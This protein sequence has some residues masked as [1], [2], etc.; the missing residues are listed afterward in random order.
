MSETLTRI[1]IMVCTAQRPRMLRDCVESLLAQQLADDWQVEVCVV[2]NDATPNSRGVV[3][4]MPTSS[5]VKVRYYQEPRRGIPFARNKTLEVGLANG[6][7][8]IVLIDDDER[9]DPTWLACLMRTAI[10]HGADV[11]SGPVRRSYEAPPP[12][13]WKLLKPIVGPAGM[14]LDEAPTNNTLLSAKLIRPDGGALRFAEALT[15]G[16]EDIDFFSR[17]YKLGFRIVWSPDAFVEETI[18]ASRVQPERLI[19]RVHSTAAAQVLAAKI[20]HGDVPTVAKFA[21]KG[22]RRLVSGAF[23]CAL[24]WPGKGLGWEKPTNSYYR[25]RLRLAR[26]LGIYRGLFTILPNYYNTVDGN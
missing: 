26:G 25:G 4:T 1:G 21:L 5:P 20:R 18:P 14:P 11:V 19:A 15:F 16:Y 12:K 10:E 9:A 13:W 24:F 2:E 17:A 6:Y 23:Q 7:D 22:I 3:E 8:W